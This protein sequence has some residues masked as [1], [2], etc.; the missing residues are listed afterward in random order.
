MTHLGGGGGLL[1]L[2][3]GHREETFCVRG[4]AVLR[5]KP[6]ACYTHK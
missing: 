2:L 3:S 1:V 6:P 5:Q 4:A